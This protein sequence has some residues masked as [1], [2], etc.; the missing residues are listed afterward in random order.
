MRL[1]CPYCNSF[2]VETRQLEVETELIRGVLRLRFRHDGLTQLT[3]CRCS[4]RWRYN[5]QDNSITRLV[6]DALPTKE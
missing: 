3:C 4:A 5:S 6:A 1:I 2:M